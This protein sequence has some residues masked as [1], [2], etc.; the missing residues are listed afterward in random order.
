MYDE[1]SKEECSRGTIAHKLIAIRSVIR[2]GMLNS[3]SDLKPENVRAF[4]EFLHKECKRALT[5]I[6][7][8]HKVIRKYTQLAYLYGFIESDPYKHPLCRFSRGTYK[9]RCPLTED[10]LVM[11]RD[12][13]DLPRKLARARDLF[14]F[15]AY[16]GLTYA[17]SQLFDF[18]LMTEFQDGLYFID[19]VRMKTGQNYFTPILPGAMEVLKRN[20][21]KVPKLSNQKANHYLHIIEK[22]LNLRKPLTVHVGRHTFA[23][24]LLTHDVPMENIGR[25]L[26]HASLKTTQIYARILHSTIQRHAAAVVTKLK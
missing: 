9:E 11:V 10:E 1:M 3:F 5:T 7:N 2:F 12:M 19:G 18:D 13:K 4:D 21:F 22:M 24:L 14:I 16:T 8:Y 20:D 26:G 23:T 17:D 15:C 6:N 25:M